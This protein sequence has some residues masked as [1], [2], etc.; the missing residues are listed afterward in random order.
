[1]VLRG[2]SYLSQSGENLED[3]VEKL[4]QKKITVISDNLFQSTP[5]DNNPLI[6]GSDRILIETASGDVS[7]VNINEVLSDNDSATITYVD[8]EIAST[9]TYVDT[10]IASTRTYVDSTVQ[11][12][13][14]KDS[15]K[16][17]TRYHL[18][19]SESYPIIDGEQLSDGDRVLVKDQDTSSAH[20]NGIYIWNSGNFGTWE[21]AEDFDHNSDTKL[22]GSFFFVEAGTDNQHMGFV[23]TTDHEID[24]Q[25]ADSGINGSEIHFT[26]FSGAGQIQVGTGLFKVGNHLSVVR[27][28][29]SSG[30][31]GGITAQEARANLGVDVAGTD[32][33]TNVSLANTDYLTI[34]GQEITANTVPIS[35][36]GTGATTAQQARTNLDVDVKGTDN[37]TNVSLANTDYLTI[38]GQVITANTVPISKGGTGAT[39]AQ[40]ARTNLDVDVKGTDNS[41]NVSLANTDYLTIS[42]QVITANTVPISKGGTGATSAST[43]RA[44]LGIQDIFSKIN[45]HPHNV[46]NGVANYSPDVVELYKAPTTMADVSHDTKSGVLRMDSLW[47]FMSP[48]TVITGTVR[49]KQP[50]KYMY[51]SHP[52]YQAYLDAGNAPIAE[53]EN[54]KLDEW[55]GYEF[56][57][58]REAL[59]VLGE[60]VKE[61]NSDGNPAV[62]GAIGG[63]VGGFMGAVAGAVITAGGGAGAAVIGAASAGAAEVAEGVGEAIK[64]AADEEDGSDLTIED[65]QKAIIEHMNN[66]EMFYNRGRQV[67]GEGHGTN[68]YLQISSDPANAITGFNTAF[69]NDANPYRVKIQGRTVFTEEV[70]CKNIFISGVNYADSATFDY[71][72]TRYSVHDKFGQV[73]TTLTSLA[74]FSIPVLPSELPLDISWAIANTVS[75][76]D[77][78]SHVLVYGH[79]TGTEGGPDSLPANWDLREIDWLT[80]TTGDGRYYTKTQSDALYLP[81]D[82]DNGIYHKDNLAADNYI[83]TFAEE[84]GVEGQAGHVPARWEMK[85]TDT[86]LSSDQN[87]YA[88]NDILADNFVLTY[89]NGEG[90]EGQAGYVA[91][92]WRL[93]D[94]EQSHWLL[95]DPSTYNLGGINSGLLKYKPPE[96]NPGDA[97]YLPGRWGYEP[98]STWKVDSNNNIYNLNLVSLFNTKYAPDGDTGIGFG[99]LNQNVHTYSPA[100]C[101]HVSGRSVLEA[102][103]SV[104]RDGTGGLIRFTNFVDAHYEQQPPVIVIHPDGTGSYARPNAPAEYVE[105]YSYNLGGIAG[106]SDGETTHNGGVVLYVATGNT[107]ENQLN[108]KMK[109]YSDKI[110]IYESLI[111]SWG[112]NIDL[113]HPSQPFDNLYLNNLVLNGTSIVGVDNNTI[114]LNSE[115]KLEVKINTNPALNAIFLLKSFNFSLD[116]GLKK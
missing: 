18:Q 50:Y 52:D 57:D 19:S 59:W 69:K 72:P 43:A 41:T 104:S 56:V 78:S 22:R 88:T 105:A 5:Y 36:G 44:N 112:R 68:Y 17:A 63:A 38:S 66:F 94:V 87:S 58:M 29:I 97:D 67:V 35:K 75:K 93:D 11:G 13:D 79:K 46:V 90:V 47:T 60:L 37:S 83:L 25:P 24:I 14:I 42:G 81:T 70:H 23:C 15:V 39:T 111:P 64:D 116:Q 95:K 80:Q 106:F 89:T 7:K 4:I 49:Y 109:I 77:G 96:G 30:G 31:T 92:S 65:V 1:M 62:W 16:V 101:L 113:G 40:Q 99:N 85:P 100:S 73:D 3:L 84:V 8:T 12:L 34:S 48:Y 6:L 2:N 54:R 51:P 26:Q 33:S 115:N 61:L 21:R 86:Y 110:N 27:V 45:H 114:T 76:A 102:D 32:N 20:K 107:Y 28:P 71:Y 9:R 55:G 74:Q 10:E 91:P 108:P 98:L 82:F 53:G 103:G